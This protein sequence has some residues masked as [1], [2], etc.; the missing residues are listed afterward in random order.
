MAGGGRFSPQR[1]QNLELRGNAAAQRGHGNVS[2]ASPGL[3]RTNERPPQRP[4]NF[5]PSANRELQVVQAT[6]P[7]IMLDW[8][9]L[10]L[11]LAPCEGDGWLAVP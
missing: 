7:G 1:P 2:A 3:T 5:A 10:P 8:P 11:L 6:I 9:A 4:Q